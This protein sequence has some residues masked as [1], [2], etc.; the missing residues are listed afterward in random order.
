VIVLGSERTKLGQK[1]LAPFITNGRA[2]EDAFEFVGLT[3]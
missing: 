2:C 1:A 3:G